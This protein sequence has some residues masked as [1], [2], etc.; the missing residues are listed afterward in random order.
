MKSTLDFEA[1]GRAYSLRLSTNAQ[2][3][4]Q[5]AAG[6]T[7]L[8]GLVAVESNPSDLDRIRRLIW[9]GMSHIEGVTEDTAGDLIDELGFD[10]AIDKLSQAVQLAYPAASADAAGNERRAKKSPKST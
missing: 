1:G 3:R 4:Y 2:I 6:E 9:A 10:V 5:R 7:F 8:Q